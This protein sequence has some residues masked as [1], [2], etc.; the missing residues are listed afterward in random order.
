M[1]EIKAGMLVYVDNLDGMRP[2][3]GVE[4][5]VPDVVG[6]ILTVDYVVKNY[7][8][9]R[10]FELAICDENIDIPKTINLNRFQ[11]SEDKYSS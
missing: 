1:F 11:D 8:I 5:P 2:V 6:K 9:L 4:E 10:E 7:Y 3:D